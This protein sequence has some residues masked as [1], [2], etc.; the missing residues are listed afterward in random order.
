MGGSWFI[1]HK[2]LALVCDPSIAQLAERGTVEVQLRSLGR[3]FK[4]GSKDTFL[5]HR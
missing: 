1:M 2:I 3:W 4:S 5:S